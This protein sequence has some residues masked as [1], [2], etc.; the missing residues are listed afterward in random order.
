MEIDKTPS[1]LS[2]KRVKP[3][4]FKIRSLSASKSSNHPQMLL[5]LKSRTEE[6]IKISHENQ[7]I[8]K[9]LKEAKPSIDVSRMKSES[10]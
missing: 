7:L 8:V 9:K 3:R 6:L 4:V 5:N 2:K 10:R 1:E